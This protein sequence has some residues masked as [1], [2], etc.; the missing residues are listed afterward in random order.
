LEPNGVAA[1]RD[2]T[3]N[4]ARSGPETGQSRETKHGGN[5]RGQG[6]GTQSTVRAEMGRAAEPS[7]VPG[8]GGR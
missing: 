1:E 5:A 7:M 2:G 3:R 4:Q 8:G 6:C